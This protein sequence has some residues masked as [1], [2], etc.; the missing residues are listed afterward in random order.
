MIK[1]SNSLMIQKIGAV[2]MHVTKRRGSR[3]S[4]IEDIRGQNS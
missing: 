2:R 1:I 4:D 3:F